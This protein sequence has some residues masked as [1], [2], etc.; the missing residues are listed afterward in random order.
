MQ[1]ALDSLIICVTVQIFHF[2]FISGVYLRCCW[3]DMEIVGWEKHW[4][5]S[6]GKTPKLVA[7]Y[8]YFT[9]FIGT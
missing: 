5:L 1:L 9:S 8:N 7:E 6:G 3:Y 2:P 4:F